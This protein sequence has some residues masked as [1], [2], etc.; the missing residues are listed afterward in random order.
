MPYV[1]SDYYKDEIKGKII[2]S[3]EKVMYNQEPTSE[4]NYFYIMKNQKLNFQ[5]AIF[6]DYPVSRHNRITVTGELAP[7]VTFRSVENVPVTYTAPE[8]DD[9]YLSKEPG[10]YPDLLKPFGEMQLILPH[11]KWVSVWVSIE[12]KEGLPVGVHDLK[13]EVFFENNEK[14]LELECKVE[15]IDANE[16]SNE[17]KL[18]NWMHYD[19]ICN[20][21]KVKPFTL[22]FYSVFKNYLQ[23]YTDLGYNMLITPL[24]TPP[25]DTKIGGERLTIQLVGVEIVDGKYKFNFT[26]LRE[27]VKF[28]RE[29]GIKYFEFSHL[30]TQWGGKC[31][32]KIIA[33]VNGKNKKIFGWHVASDSPKYSEFLKEFLP[34]LFKEIVALKIKDVS[35]M[36]LTDE[37]NVKNIEEYSKCCELIKKYMPQIPTMDAMSSPIFCEKGIVDI[38]VPAVEHFEE[39][40]D[41]ELKEKFVYYC[42]FPNNE[43]YVNR[44]I[45]MPG[46]RTRILGYLLYKK[47]TKGFLHWGFNFYNSVLSIESINPYANTDSSGFFPGGDGFIVYPTDGK[48]NYSIRAELVKESVQDYNSLLTLE[49]LTNKEF[50]MEILEKAGVKGYNDFIRDDAK[51]INL[52]NEIYKQIKKYSK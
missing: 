47:Q 43:Y 25:L 34:S 4:E 18:T 8:A 12:N 52:K 40:K 27:F 31:C 29:N 19:C 17:L 20:Y 7:Y 37:P 36:H 49:S 26:K 14:K 28:A 35:Y 50:V 3:I 2:S 39:F 22:K 23:A 51:F 10:L 9:Y 41:I 11:K 13:F 30:F 16:K 48:L 44:F 42:C 21:H 32:P 1:Y 24:F 6:H 33:K 5:V 38:P 46:L 45:N 15:V